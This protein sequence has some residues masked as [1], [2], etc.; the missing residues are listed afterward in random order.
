M[1]LIDKQVFNID[2]DQLA[3]APGLL[4]LA[5]NIIR[6]NNAAAKNVEMKWVNWGLQLSLWIGASKGK[7]SVDDFHVY[8]I[9]SMNF[10]LFYV[11]F[12]VFVSGFCNFFGTIAN[13]N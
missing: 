7:G 8:I 10:S 9:T 2:F 6:A 13:R 11:L 4:H 1:A 12:Y 5:Q 3:I